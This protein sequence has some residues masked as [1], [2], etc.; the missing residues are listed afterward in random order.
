[1]GRSEKKRARLLLLL[2][3]QDGMCPL[4]GM[5]IVDP[6]D[7]NLDHK[8]PRARGGSNERANLQATHRVC[9]TFKG[10][11]LMI[12]SCVG[13]RRVFRD[14]ERLEHHLLGCAADRT[15]ARL[16]AQ[17]RAL[18]RER[19]NGALLIVPR[20]MTKEGWRRGGRGRR[21]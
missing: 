9:N 4:C 1:M 8:V 16:A 2:E 11:A 19:R 12:A 6:A 15:A 10:A 20:A 5:A 14:I 13:C 21:G 18:A 17:A 3:E 7:A